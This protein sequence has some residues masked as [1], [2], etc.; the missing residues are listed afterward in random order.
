[1]LE[2]VKDELG[3][4]TTYAKGTDN[5][6]DNIALGTSRINGL[7]LLPGQ[8]ASTSDM[9]LE[10]IAENGYKMAPQYM[11][12]STL[13]AV[14]GGVCQVS[15]TLYNAL[16]RA[17]LQ[18]DERHSHSMSVSYL[19]PSFDAAIAWQAK[20][21]RFTNNKEYPIYIEGYMKG[22]DVTF[23]VYGFEDRPANRKVVYKSIVDKEVPAEDKIVYDPTQ[24]VGYTAKKGQRHNYIES[25][26]IKIVYIDGEE[27]SR[28]TINKD[29]YYPQYVTVTIGT[30]EVPAE[31]VP[32]ETTPPAA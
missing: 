24:P 18:I 16:L 2:A 8:S 25:H 28:E 27:V 32:A 21:L 17:E 26:L 13:D 30:M 23:T 22:R 3:T 14:G 12:G 15:S 11:N 9:M 29:T 20:D 19:E 5:R 31:T 7:L 10:R 6:A 1:M 4:C